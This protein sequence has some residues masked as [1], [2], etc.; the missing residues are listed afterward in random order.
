MWYLWI[1]GSWAYCW[2]SAMQEW[3]LCF[4]RDTL[5]VNLWKTSI[6]RFDEIR[7]RRSALFIQRS[8]L[9]EGRPFC[10]KPTSRNAG[11][12]SKTK[13]F[14]WRGT[15]VWMGGR[16]KAWFLDGLARP[17]RIIQFWASSLRI[18]AVCCCERAR[19]CSP[20]IAPEGVQRAWRE[21]WRSYR[22]E[23]SSDM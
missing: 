4:R 22:W 21:C 12:R 18:D 8:S 11:E 10:S 13:N 19:E 1:H 9:D 6:L 5:Q 14:S 7:R 23:R 3:Y 16:R 15:W 17:A 2:L 20:S